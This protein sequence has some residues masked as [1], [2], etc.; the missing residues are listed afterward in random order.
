MNFTSKEEYGL[1]AMMHLAMHEAA[2]PI[3]AREIASQEG[4]PEQ[5]LEQVL[6]ALRRAG[7]VRSVRGASG[8]YE[9]ARAAHAVTAG[10]V[11]RA[12]SGPI[13]PIACVDDADPSD[14]CNKLES[15]VVLSLW[16]KVQS[17]VSD[18]LD[19]TTIQDM[20]DG[21]IRREQN[22]SYAMYI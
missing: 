12:L 9:L 1:R 21:R 22:I 7:L 15:C 10:D 20:V 11:M 5:F 16:K 18:I 17:A 2:W 14:R 3:Q 8:G 19:D 6:A 13:A 4:I